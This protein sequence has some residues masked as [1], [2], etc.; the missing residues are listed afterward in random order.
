[1]VLSPYE[2]APA[3]KV[4]AQVPNPAHAEV[5]DLDGDGIL[6]IVVAC[7]GSFGPTDGSGEERRCRESAVTKG[8]DS[9]G[10]CPRIHSKDYRAGQ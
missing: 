8:A 1:M 4:L 2:T 9:S 5:I 6:D 7:L 3:W 10:P